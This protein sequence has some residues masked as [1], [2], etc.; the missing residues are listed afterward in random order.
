MTLLLLKWLTGTKQGRRCI[1]SGCIPLFI[2]HNLRDSKLEVLPAFLSR[3]L[4]W[5]P[6]S[7]LSM[8]SESPWIQI[9]PDPS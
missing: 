8:A 7:S 1:P 6:S 5:C 3:D 2:S 9:K 4:N